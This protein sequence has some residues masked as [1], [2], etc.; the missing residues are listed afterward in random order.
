[1]GNPIATQNSNFICFAFP[2]V[3]NTQV[4]TSVVAIPYPNTGNLGDAS[5][6]SDTVRVGGR[7]IIHNESEISANQ[8]IGSEAALLNGGVRSQST[9]G[10]V[11]F[12]SASQSV[13]VHG[14]G[15]VRMFDTTE[16]NVGD[17][18]EQANANG[19]VLGGDT[20]VLVG[21]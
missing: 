18:T 12:K 5:N 14:K 7:P 1:M 6:V 17:G 8:T 3:C 16:H 11:K 9:R 21:D 10:K 19:S 20:T 4:G 15:V 2:D 13:R